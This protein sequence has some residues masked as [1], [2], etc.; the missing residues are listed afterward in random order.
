MIKRETN[1]GN[2]M[3]ELSPETKIIRIA[4]A[5]VE[6]ERLLNKEL[7]YMPQNQKKDVI[8]SYRLH[9][10]KLEKMK[11]LEMEKL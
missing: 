6:T 4:Q 9:I 10:E 7:S 8:E 5:L 11:E 3:R 1:K 2:N